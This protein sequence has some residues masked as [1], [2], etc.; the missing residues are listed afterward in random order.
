MQSLGEK[1]RRI[2]EIG[3]CKSWELVLY[4]FS[5]ICYCLA[6]QC[7]CYCLFLSHTLNGMMYGTVCSPREFQGQFRG[8]EFLKIKYFE[9]SVILNENFL[10]SE[11]DRFFKR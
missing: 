6:K 11:V 3:R 4:F 1:K 10:R 8:K 2:E 9:G 7:T 5:P